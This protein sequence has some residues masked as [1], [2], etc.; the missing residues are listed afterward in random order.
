[1]LSLVCCNSISDRDELSK[2]GCSDCLH[3]N[4]NASY[5]AGWCFREQCSLII[6]WLAIHPEVIGH[7]CQSV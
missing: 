4:F 3:V 7:V 6:G 5:Q 1:M 2:H